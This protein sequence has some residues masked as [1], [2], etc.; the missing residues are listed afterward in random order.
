MVMQL[1][2]GDH[3]SPEPGYT[4]IPAGYRPDAQWAR[5]RARAIARGMPSADAYFRTLPNARS[6]TQLLADNTIWINYSATIGGY[7][8]TNAVGG[9]EIAIGSVAF[10][11]GRWTVLATLIHELAHSNGAP[12]GASKAAEQALVACGLGKRGELNSGV[13]DPRTPFDP[14]ISG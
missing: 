12:G 8:E 11:Y 13:D 14:N 2:L 4:A 9:K 7:G 10:R 1:N 6:L 5:T 3:V